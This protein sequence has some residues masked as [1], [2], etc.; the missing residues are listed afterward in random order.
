M[1]MSSSWDLTQVLVLTAAGMISF[2]II[3]LNFDRIHL[4]LIFDLHHELVL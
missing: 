4:L 3:F 1:Q 2:F